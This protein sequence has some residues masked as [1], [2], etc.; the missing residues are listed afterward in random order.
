[1]L[2]RSADPPDVR[3]F[4]FPDTGQTVRVL[5]HDSEHWWVARD[6]AAVLGYRTASDATRWLD[7]DE[8]GTHTVRT[9]G[10]DQQMV[11]VSEAG[12]YSLILR[13]RR[14]EARAFRRWVTHEVLPV[15]RRTGRYEA[16]RPEP[17]RLELAR[18]LVAALEVR[19]L[20]E[21]RNAALEPSANAWDTLATDAIGDYSVRE[22][23]QL[24]SRAGIQTGQNRLFA[25]LRE[26]GW[27][28][29]R[30][31]PYQAQVDNGRLVQRVLSYDHPHSRE[32]KL[33]S[34]VRIT[35]TGLA[36]LQQRLSGQQ[37]LI[38]ISCPRA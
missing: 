37:P 30:G 27:I 31:R 10:G 34:Q 16:Q 24:L 20:L 18:D 28:D 38:P 4:P 7:D 21:Q 22:A 25:S 8:K 5:V 2:N 33:T 3:A 6:V 1:M 32:P 19:E 13:S 35:P 15:L 29:A 14:R 36:A 17:T 11:T 26:L 9:P 23:A 12:L